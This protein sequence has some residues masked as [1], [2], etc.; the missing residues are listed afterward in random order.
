M[1]SNG[2]SGGDDAEVVELRA[3]IARLQDEVDRLRLQGAGVHP[4][5]ALLDALSHGDRA[6]DT[7]DSAATMYLSS[8]S[9]RSELSHLLSLL[10]ATVSD[11]E[12]R[13]ERLDRGLDVAATAFAADEAQATDAATG[14]VIDLRHTGTQADGHAPA[15]RF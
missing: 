12:L 11:F 2:R 8:L 10:K 1:F 9:I 13:L 14:H 6:A 4:G 5:S 15:T 7:A 3:E